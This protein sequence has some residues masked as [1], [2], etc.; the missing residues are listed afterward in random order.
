M[1]KLLIISFCFLFL[2]LTIGVAMTDENCKPIDYDNKMMWDFYELVGLYPI[3]DA[4]TNQP[5]KYPVG[6]S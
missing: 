6:C 2:L 4:Q 5:I 1:N 3:I